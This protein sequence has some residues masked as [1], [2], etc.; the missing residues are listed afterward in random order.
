MLAAHHYFRAGRSRRLLCRRDAV[1]ER[2]VAGH[3][4]AAKSA[5]S[6]TDAAAA[7]ADWQ[8]D[9]AGADRYRAVG[10]P[11]S[12]RCTGTEKSHGKPQNPVSKLLS[13]AQLTFHREPRAA[14]CIGT[15]R[16]AHCHHA[17]LRPIRGARHARGRGRHRSE[18][19]GQRRRQS[20]RRQRRQPGAKPRRQGVRRAHQHQRH[21]DD[22]VAADHCAE[23]AAGANLAGQVNV[24]DV[25]LP[26]GGLKLSVANEVKP[27]L[28]ATCAIRWL[29]WK[30]ICGT[31]RSSKMPRAPNGPS[32]AIRFARCRG[33]GHAESVA[34]S[35][36]YTRHRGAAADRRP[37]GHAAGRRASA[38][39][40]RADPD[41]SRLPFPQAARSG[42]GVERWQRDIAVPID[43]PFTE[44]SRLLEAQ[45]AGK[46]F[47][48][49]GSGEFAAR[50]NK[51]AS[52][53]PAIGC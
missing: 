51:R 28:D 42:F 2:A 30:R 20:H 6:C 22:G 29:R 40:H 10:N 13:T 31:I 7:A 46:T 34:R 25:V 19:R 15:A 50:S 36:A 33:A 14:R 53:R 44:L 4:G 39:P 49:D 21:G 12:A 47:P 23:L 26:I 32:C 18:H 38:N 16:H 35:A 17:A 43:I 1:V 5:K 27:A 11:R 3:A 45:F 48:E 9:R 41:P 24:V 37:R 52:R 8:F